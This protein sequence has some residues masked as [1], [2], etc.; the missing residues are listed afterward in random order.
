MTLSD[1]IVT[2]LTSFYE[3]L[4]HCSLFKKIASMLSFLRKNMKV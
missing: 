3:K 1:D 4:K 2:D